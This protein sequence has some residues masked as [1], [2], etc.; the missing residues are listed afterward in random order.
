MQFYIN[1]LKASELERITCKE[2]LNKEEKIRISQF[3]TKSSKRRV[4]FFH[5]DARRETITMQ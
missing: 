4:K 3:V 5:N 2:L 1:V